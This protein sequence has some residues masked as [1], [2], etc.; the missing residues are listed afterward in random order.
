MVVTMRCERTQFDDDAVL[1]TEY[2]GLIACRQFLIRD[3]QTLVAPHSMSFLDAL[4]G[5]DTLRSLPSNVIGLPTFQEMWERYAQSELRRISGHN[6]DRGADASIWYVLTPFPAEFKGQGEAGSLIYTEFAGGTGRRD[7]EVWP[8]HVEVAPYETVAAY[9][10]EPV[11][12]AVE[13]GVDDSGRAIPET[14]RPQ[15]ISHAEFEA[16][17]EKHAIPRLRELARRC[18]PRRMRDER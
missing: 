13:R 17:W 12:A 1:Y 9:D 5:A 10:V 18:D 7:F 14:M 3:G 4:G 8:D 2:D 16:Q 6:D 11:I 15:R